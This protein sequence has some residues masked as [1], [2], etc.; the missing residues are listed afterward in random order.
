M[1]ESGQTM[2]SWK[3][4]L[5]ELKKKL[6]LK[7][8]EF[9]VLVVFFLFSLRVLNWF[10]YPYI[11]VSGDFRPP[12]VHEAFVKRVLYTW[13][14]TDFGIPSVYSPRILDPFYFLVTALQALGVSLYL[15]QIIATFLIYL[16]S[17]ILMY[18][19]VKQLTNGN[20]TASFVAALYLTSNVYLIN[21]REV[22]AIGFMNI[23]LMILPCLITFVKGVKTRSYKLVTV[24]GILCVLTYATFPNYRTTLICLIMLGLIS[25]LFFIGKELQ[26]SLDDKE[27]SQKVFKISLNITLLCRYLKLLAIFG[28]AFFLVSIWLVVIIFSNFDILT[29][30]YAQIS[31]PWFTG[32]LSISNVTRLIARWGF[33][34][35]ALGKPYIPYREMYLSNPLLI[36]LCYLPAIL[37]F[38]SLLLSKE[39]KIT[40]FFSSVAIVFMFL[41]SGFSFSEYG[42]SLYYDLMGLPLLNAFREASNWIFFVIISFGILIGC[43]ISA[44]C[45]KFKNKVSRILVIALVATLFL[46]STY[47]LT[48]GDVTRNWLNPEM[49]GTY[50]PPS[51]VELNGMLPSEYWTIM[52]PQRG[53]YVVLNI[54]EG[55][56]GCGNPY[57]LIFSKPIIS[58]AGTEYIQSENLDLI[59]ELHKR[60]RTNIKYENVAP[61]GK[62]SASS[63]ET[64]ERTPNKAIDGQML[65]RWA[66]KVGVPQ[67]LEIEWN[68]PQELAKINIFFESAYADDYIIETWN[69]SDWTTLKIVKNNTSTEYEYVFPKTINTT[70]L[71]LFFTKASPW[72]L[73]SI[74]ELEVYVRTEGVPKFLGMLGIKYLIL[75]KNIVFGNTYPVSMLRLHENKNFT[76][77]KE[78]EEIAL[79]ENSYAL[80]KLYVADNILNFS[81][82]N[83]M[84][85]LI[86]HS[87]WNTLKHSVFINTTSPNEANKTLIEPK[88]FTWREASPTKY[89][90]NVESNG[91]FILVFLGSYDEHWKAYVNGNLIPETNHLEVNAFANGWLIDATGNLTIT[92]QYETQNLL[93]VSIAASIILPMLLLML[94]SRTDLKKNIYLIHHKLKSI[95]VRLKQKM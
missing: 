77:V 18:I 58:G 22:T 71:R 63:S 3:A 39:H 54:T 29:A 88:N 59:N 12:L 40:I 20:I 53:A 89:E 5:K 80:K 36:F 64:N 75:E 86:E 93:T 17:S 33:H 31:T 62:A 28:I 6:G 48:T 45:R 9:L 66:S 19:F 52:L 83:D 81:T 44:L 55:M 56:L 35:S 72:G 87:E 91:S 68:K 92:I 50:F 41:T 85:E 69:G 32:G 95:Q 7:S 74:W 14:E 13:D 16:F 8:T 84:Y 23:T 4:V 37:A 70:K 51:Y 43:T 25:I 90:A 57:P 38:T 2:L 67:W 60:R 21:D 42:N 10:Q 27:G 11:V 30:T 79:F 49:K 34:A 78:W 94:L 15:S 24:S 65:T 61:E 82:L 46:S 26:I 47:P 76:L 73:I 1:Q